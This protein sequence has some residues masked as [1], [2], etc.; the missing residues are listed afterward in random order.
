VGVS[1]AM[2]LIITGRPV[3]AGEAERIGLV[4]RVVP[5]GKSLAAAR[6][7]AAGLAAFPQTCL[8]ED[9]LSLLEQQGRTEQDA[10][11]SELAH[12]RTSLADAQPGLDRFRSGAG[13]HGEF[14]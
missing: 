12:G 3:G 6:E 5:A 9:R 2:D 14:P 13:R 7:L 10:I 4:N 8:R 11:D 1:R